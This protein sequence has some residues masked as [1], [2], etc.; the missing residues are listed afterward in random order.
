MSKTRWLA[1]ACRFL[2]ILTVWLPLAACNDDPDTDPNTDEYFAENPLADE[3]GTT[4]AEGQLQI[5]PSSVAVTAI[6]EEVRFSALG[7]DSP[8][9]WDLANSG[10][11]EIQGD[12]DQ[13][14]YKVRQ[15]GDNNIV[16]YDSLGHSAVATILGANVGEAFVLVADDTTLDNNGDKTVV[17]VAGGVAPFTWAISNQELGRIISNGSDSPSQIYERLDPGDNAI[18]VTDSLGN[19][20]SIVIKQPATP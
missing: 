4:P 18:Q 3:S 6:G 12:G 15:I 16:V 20:A 14:I 8:Y 1:V 11:G 13:V 2:A 7:G 17:T 10:L 9:S 19:T 5:S